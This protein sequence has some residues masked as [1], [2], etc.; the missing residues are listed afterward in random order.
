MSIMIKVK[1]TVMLTALDLATKRT[2]AGAVELSALCQE[3]SSQ[4][5]V[6]WIRR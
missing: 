6:C 2:F 4:A 5:G 1:G 3:R